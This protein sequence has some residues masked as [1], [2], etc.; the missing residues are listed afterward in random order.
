MAQ[1]SDRAPRLTGKLARRAWHE[2]H[3]RLALLI[4]LVLVLTPSIV[5]G[6]AGVWGLSALEE[7]PEAFHQAATNVAAKL[8]SR[9]RELIRTVPLAIPKMDVEREPGLDSGGS[10]MRPLLEEEAYQL[11]REYLFNTENP[12]L[13]ADAALTF[14]ATTNENGQRVVKLVKA[15]APKEIDNL[16][17][18]ATQAMMHAAYRDLRAAQASSGHH[19]VLR[20]TAGG[21]RDWMVYIMSVN[22]HDW[23]HA[24][25]YWVAWVID[26]SAI[27]E[28]LQQWVQELRNT[29]T[30]LPVDF[31]IHHWAAPDPPGE[32]LRFALLLDRDVLPAWRLW[33]SV[34]T[35]R[36][37]IDRVQ[38]RSLLY[39]IF[40]T[41]SVPVAFLALMS[42]AYRI[43]RSIADARNKVDFVANVTHELRTP[44]TSIRMFTETLMSGRLRNEEDRQEA[45]GII[46]QETERLERLI[47]RVL[48]F[49]KLE[50]QTRIFTIEPAN[51][52]EVVRG[53][54]KV[55]LAGEI[56]TR[57]PRI[58][59]EV[60]GDLTAVECD[61]DAMREVIL[62]L[63]SNAEKYAGVE[64]PV[65][66][67]AWSDRRHAWLEVVDRGP[68]I[69]EE[70]QAKIFEKFYRANDTLNR[71]VEGTGLGL[72]ICR[73]IV[74]A[75]RGTIS[76]SS[77]PG[78]GSTFTIRFPLR[79]DIPAGVSG[80][81][82]PVGRQHQ[83]G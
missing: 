75:H 65:T 64:L 36:L 27:H 14:C 28:R 42:I 20:R 62:N 83:P 35:S 12:D 15:I 61:K 25:V 43:R 69:P 47:S 81:F 37:P 10:D 34:D 53:A 9:A 21:G 46:H 5:M 50:R 79:K 66:V 78:Q 77:R 55:F 48:E 30:R 19:T 51:F 74:R 60:S 59:I 4:A 16:T 32:G 31:S 22:S 67:R 38:W 71:K 17:S 2:R 8:N 56:G 49:N 3:P 40:A 39:A 70:E 33:V 29:E 80:R 76:V 73:H 45:L 44:L 54:V 58:D 72:A 57:H 52:E 11:Q 24:G 1:S 7:E 6:F 26:S 41:L 82:A 13:I 63:L 18:P 68:G 23:D